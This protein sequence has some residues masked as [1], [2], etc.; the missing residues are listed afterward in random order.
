MQVTAP[1]K[2]TTSTSYNGLTTTVTDPN[3]NQTARTSDGLGRLTTVQEYSGKSVYATTL[4]TYDVADHL[5]TTKDAQGNVSTLQYDW[6][7]RKASMKDPDMGTWTYQYDPLGNFTQQTDA[8]S[9]NLTFTYD[10][11]N[12]LKVKHDATNHVDLATYGYGTTVGSIGLRTSMTDQSGSTSWSYNNY[13]R[14]VQETRTI[15]TVANQASITASDWLGRVLTVQ[16]PD[17]EAVSY[18]YDALGRAKNA[19][20]SQA[21]NLATLAYNALSQ[22]TTSSLGNGVTV[23]NSYNSATNR[24]SERSTAVNSTKLID[25]SYLY[26]QTGNITNIADSALGEN[27]NLPV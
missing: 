18:T 13:G 11:L 14:T 19:S 16:Y 3:G 7:G 20:G 24:L 15:G 8:R 10:N 26:D 9:Q 17:Q 22:L 25:F 2:I 5:L 12:R 23:T 1:G 6:S 4:Y 27:P 21:G